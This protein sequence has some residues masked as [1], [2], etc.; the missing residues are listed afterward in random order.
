MMKKKN[1]QLLDEVDHSQMKYEEFD[2]D[3]YDEHEEIKNLDEK[4]VEELRKE[5]KIKIKGI[6]P[7]KPI[8]SFAHL[9][10]TENIVQ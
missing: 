9:N 1:F 4:K 6:D 8:V 7:P 10:F 2:K 5:F 3:F